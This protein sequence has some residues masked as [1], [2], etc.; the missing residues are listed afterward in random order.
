MK[1][2]K[3]ERGPVIINGV[4]AN[5]YYITREG[6]VW[7]KMK[8]KY[9]SPNKNEYLYIGIRRK[10]KYYQTVIHRLVAKAFIP[11][12]DKT[13]TIVNHKNGNKYDNRVENLEWVTPSYNSIHA[14]ATGLNKKTKTSV[15]QCTKKGKKLK[16][17]E[18]IKS[19]SDVLNISHQ[20]ISR[21]CRLKNYTAGGFK[22]E[23]ENSQ[24]NTGTQYGKYKRVEQIDPET[25]KILK[26]YNNLKIAAD[27]MDCAESSIYNS[28]RE[29]TRK[30]RG[31]LWKLETPDNN[32]IPLKNTASHPGVELRAVKINKELS[33]IYFAVKSGRIWSTTLKGYLVGGGKRYLQVILIHKKERYNFRVHRLIAE[34]FVP[35]PHNYKIVNHIDGNKQNNKAE[36]LE[37]CTL[38]QNANH[39]IG[40]GLKNTYSTPVIQLSLNGDKLNEFDS[41]TNAAIETGSSVSG[42]SAVCT[43]KINQTN[44][45]KWKYK[46]N[47]KTKTPEKMRAVY[48]YEGEIIPFDMFIIKPVKKRAKN[49]IQYTKDG[50]EV[51][52]YDSMKDASEKNNIDSRL[53]SNVCKGRRNTAG[54]YVWSYVGTEPTFNKSKSKKVDQ[55]NIQTGEI[56]HTYE[57]AKLASQAVNCSTGSMSN[58]LTGR[59]KNL[60]GYSWKYS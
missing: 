24:K 51:C 20:L 6:L 25:G 38:S 52:Q 26:V 12:T 5:N 7:S 36:N 39:A 13:L 56:I 32:I 50:I 59:I 35:N 33:T 23:Y 11:N 55:I 57:S 9:M 30:T 60:K 43:G 45:F 29:K 47:S 41:M 21:A 1:P 49:I 42:I 48:I 34:A 46:I 37:W 28:C 17:F 15:Y 19:A 31:F 8:K 54:G 18:S 27:A 22:W 4:V 44:N 14:H 10:N 53:I 16:K 58:A 2:I 3:S 40:M